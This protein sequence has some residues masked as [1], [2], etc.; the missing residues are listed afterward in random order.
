MDWFLYDRDFRHEKVNQ[1]SNSLK[2]GKDI[3]FDKG[4]Q[5]SFQQKK[6]KKKKKKK[7]MKTATLA[8]PVL[9]VLTVI[10]SNHLRQ[11]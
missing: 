1:I 10:M 6:K 11:L 3:D 7:M 5:I 2:K 4:Y 8:I 9:L